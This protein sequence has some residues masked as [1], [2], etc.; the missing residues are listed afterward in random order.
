MQTELVS[1]TLISDA[2]GSLG[3]HVLQSIFTQFP[4]D[5]FKLQTIKFVRSEP[6]LEQCLE[7]LEQ[8]SG[9]VVHAT[10][11]DDFKQR[12]ESVCRARKLPVYDLTGPIMRFF[13]D[14][15][16]KKP[17]VRYERL[18]ELNSDYFTR[19]DAIEF[20]IGHD[21]GAGLATLKEAEVILTGVSRTSKTPTTMFLAVAGL[22]AANVP[23]VHGL[24]PPQEL[25]S[26]Q[27][28]RVVCLV[29]HPDH[30]M[31]VRSARA[32]AGLGV[33][34]GDYVDEQAI[35]REL[36]WSR[37]FSTERGWQVLDVTGRAIEE[38]A[39]RVIELCR[40]VKR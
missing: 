11:Y 17:D 30:L 23:L 10:I 35:R 34:G 31:M 39:S 9:L 33:A 21:D 6:D 7:R 19:V 28:K 26:A 22:R 25:L 24:V 37:R 8:T 29:L 2:T 13:V 14:S 38:T 16:G 36:T 27:S 3:E 40:L 4:P 20:A 12:I 32:K 1:V 15:S 5:S 18:H